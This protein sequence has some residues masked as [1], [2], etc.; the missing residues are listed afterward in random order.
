MENS[1]EYAENFKSILQT[2]F[3]FINLFI[4]LC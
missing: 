3:I 1:N 2:I 4:L